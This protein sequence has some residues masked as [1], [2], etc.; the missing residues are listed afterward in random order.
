[1]TGPDLF[2]DVER[3]E[4]ED[5]TLS[6]DD[7]IQPDGDM[8]FDVR[9]ILSQWATGVTYDES[10]SF[11]IGFA[12]I[13]TALILIGIPGPPVWIANG[14]LLLGLIAGGVAVLGIGTGSGKLSRYVRLEPHY[15]IGGQAIAAAVGALCMALIRSTVWLGGL[16]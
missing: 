4:T 5:E 6:G 3:A 8:P 7:R 11:V 12:P 13:F 15:L 1:M 14:L 10:H 9:G 16:A 2:D